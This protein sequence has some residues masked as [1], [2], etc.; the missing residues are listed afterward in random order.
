MV[1][2]EDKRKERQNNMTENLYSIVFSKQHPK[3][4]ESMTMRW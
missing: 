3:D 2:L 1:L 4:I